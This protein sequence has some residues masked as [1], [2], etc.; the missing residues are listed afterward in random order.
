MKSRQLLQEMAATGLTPESAD[1]LKPY[2]K[3]LQQAVA[4]RRVVTRSLEDFVDEQVGDLDI[5]GKLFP[6]LDP[7]VDE[8]AYMKAHDAIRDH[9]VSELAHA[10]GK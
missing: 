5:V 6:N 8:L 10:S 3:R 4:N 9:L 2:L 7:S 1:Q